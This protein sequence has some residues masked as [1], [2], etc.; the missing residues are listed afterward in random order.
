MG[1]HLGPGSVGQP[2]PNGRRGRSYG[3]LAAPAGV[4]GRDWR[5]GDG[6]VTHPANSGIPARYLDG[7]YAS[8]NPGWHEAD[9][10]WKAD[11]V[12]SMLLSHGLAP[13]SICDVGCGTGHLLRVLRPAFPDAELY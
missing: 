11:Q 4:P 1:P 2:A 8:Q 7:T 9:A 3:E 5:R 6:S 10:P 13:S 12:L